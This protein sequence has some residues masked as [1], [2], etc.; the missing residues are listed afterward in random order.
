MTRVNDVTGKRIVLFGF[1]ESVE[2]YRMN[3][4]G[5]V[6]EPCRINDPVFSCV[7]IKAM[8]GTKCMC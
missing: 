1:I 2:N 8:E 7:R 4:K 6:Q 3:E 5:T